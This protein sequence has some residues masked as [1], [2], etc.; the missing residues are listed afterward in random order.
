MAAKQFAAGKMRMAMQMY[1]DAIRLSPSTHTLYSNRSACHCALGDYHLAFEDACKCIDLMPAWP[2]GHVRKGAALHGMDRWGEAVTAY[3][4]GL[5]FDPTSESL[6][7]GIDDAKRRQALAGGEWIFVG[8]RRGDDGCRVLQVPIAFCAAPA[9]GLCILD[10]GG[11]NANG[12]T[13]LVTNHDVTYIKL[14]INSD[15]MVNRAGLFGQP[16]VRARRHT[17]KHA[18]SGHAACLDSSVTGSLPT[19]V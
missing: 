14:S 7:Q 11:Q 18:C 15:Q 13:V 2:K 6:R 16:H 10:N 5:K 8:N 9:N 1:T 4:A 17:H 19:R 3:E 12:A